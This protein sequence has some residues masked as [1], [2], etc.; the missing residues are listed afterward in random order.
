ME[1]RAGSDRSF[2]KPPQANVNTKQNTGIPPHRPPADRRSTLNRRGARCISENGH[3]KRCTHLATRPASGTIV[4]ARPRRI[5]ETPAGGMS[6]E[7]KTET[8][9]FHTFQQID[10][11]PSVHSFP[12]CSARNAARRSEGVSRPRKRVSH[13]FL[14]RRRQTS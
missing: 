12:P 6:V 2:F 9:Y 11:S 8:C 13:L 7:L 3:A 5:A 10:L 4:L 1:P 14:Q